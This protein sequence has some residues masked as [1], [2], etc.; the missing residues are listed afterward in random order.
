ML[1]YI[2]I[3][4]AGYLVYK[5]A[6]NAFRLTISSFQPPPELKVTTELIKCDHCG[7]FVGQ[8][9]VIQKDGKNFCSEACRK[10]QT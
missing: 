7:E 9:N 5:I 6:K 1:K 8:Q 10:Q 3:I 2:I 4:A